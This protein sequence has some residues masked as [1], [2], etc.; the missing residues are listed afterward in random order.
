ML[1]IV[2]YADIV[3]Q[4][5]PKRKSFT[6]NVRILGAPFRQKKQPR[7]FTARGKRLPHFLLAFFGDP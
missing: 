1:P 3:T 7:M 6:R 5:R 2:S 4:T